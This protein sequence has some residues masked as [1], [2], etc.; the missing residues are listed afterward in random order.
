MGPLTDSACASVHACPHFVCAFVGPLSDAYAPG[1]IWFNRGEFVLSGSEAKLARSQLPSDLRFRKVDVPCS[2]AGPA[3][4]IARPRYQQLPP[5]PMIT[6][7][8]SAHRLGPSVLS[9]P[10][11]VPPSERDGLGGTWPQL[12]GTKGALGRYWGCCG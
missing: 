6:S 11:S 9:D 8:R 7:C 5:I 10:P 3:A 1:A 4:S 12:E 2:P